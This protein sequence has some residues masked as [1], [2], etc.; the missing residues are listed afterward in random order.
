MLLRSQ[1]NSN[2]MSWPPLS[3]ALL[4]S[5][6]LDIEHRMSGALLLCPKTRAQQHMISAGL[7]IQLKNTCVHL[8]FTPTPK[9]CK[10]GGAQ[11]RCVTSPKRP[12]KPYMALRPFL[13]CK[14]AEAVQNA[15]HSVDVFF[16][17]NRGRNTRSPCFCLAFLPCLIKH[18][19]ADCMFF[20]SQ[21]PSPT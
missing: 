19:N 4:W 20:C 11:E 9:T 17:F 18:L 7:F 3:L 16:C 6:K 14:C 13:C 10:S 12:C 2:T 1:R 5:P 15:S 21:G 8:P